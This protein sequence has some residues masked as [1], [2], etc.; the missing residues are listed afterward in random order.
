MSATTTSEAPLSRTPVP[1]RRAVMEQRWEDVTFLHWPYDPAAVQQVLP[2]GVQVDTFDGAAWVSLVPFRMVDLRLPGRRPLPFG[3]FPEV[4]VRT[5]VRHGARRGVWFFS[6]DID[7]IAPTVVA[8]TLYRLPYCQGR[9]DHV[10]VGDLEESLVAACGLPSPSGAPLAMWCRG[11]D[12]RV[13]AP[14]S[15]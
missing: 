5:Y 1:L 8:R 9:V 3:T 4:N 11:V 10:R 7:R 6:L 13:G 15:A 14:T 2:S 12:V